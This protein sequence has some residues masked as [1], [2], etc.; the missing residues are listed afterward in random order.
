MLYGFLSMSVQQYNCCCFDYSL[1]KCLLCHSYIERQI[2]VK[3]VEGN[4]VEMVER[5]KANVAAYCTFNMNIY[6]LV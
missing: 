3:T 6:L 4:E 1:S 5:N 2:K